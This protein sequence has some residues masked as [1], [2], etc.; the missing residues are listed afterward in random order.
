MKKLLLIFAVMAAVLT[1]CGGG[2]TLV[3]TWKLDSVSGEELSEDEKGGTMTFNEDGTCEN[4][5]GDQTM[6]AEWKLS[7][8]KKTLT[9]MS[10]GREE[11]LNDIEITAETFSF[12]DGSDK[13]TFKKVD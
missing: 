10:D 13:V 9:I 8:D 7:D 2:P 11:E 1:S 12:N 3:G 5:R 4:K 6:K